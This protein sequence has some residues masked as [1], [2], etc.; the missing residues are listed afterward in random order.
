MVI[1]QQSSRS[2]TIVWFVRA[3]SGLSE[4]LDEGEFLLDL[5]PKV[6]VPG[7]FRTSIGLSFGFLRNFKT[8]KLRMTLKKRLRTRNIMNKS[9]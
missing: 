2:R 7:F 1:W 4:I 9:K 5:K 8:V 6:L 3:I